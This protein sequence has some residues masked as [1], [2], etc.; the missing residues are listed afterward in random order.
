MSQNGKLIPNL[1]Q[2][3]TKI[4]NLTVLQRMDPY[5]EEILITAAHVSFYEFNVDINQWVWFRFLFF[6]LSHLTFMLQ[7]V[8]ETVLECPAKVSIYS[9]ESE[10]YRQAY[11]SFILSRNFLAF[12][13][14]SDLS[15]DFYEFVY[16]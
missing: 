15:I 14:A 6:F 2:N 11:C 9:N 7:F 4:L 12:P 1:D 8:R 16:L 10:K 5:I 13:T 3:S